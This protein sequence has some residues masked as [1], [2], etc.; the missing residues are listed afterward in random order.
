MENKILAHNLDDRSVWR[1]NDVN[2]HN[3]LE[4]KDNRDEILIKQSFKASETSKSFRDLIPVEKSISSIKSTTFSMMKIN[5]TIVNDLKRCGFL[6]PSPIQ[7]SCIPLA[8]LG[9]DLIAQSKSGT[10]KTLVFVICSLEMI[11]EEIYDRGNFDLPKSVRALILIPTHEIANQIAEIIES[12]TSNWKNFVCYRAIG[13]T[14]VSDDLDRLNQAQIVVGT[15]GRV[16]SLLEW[17]HLKTHSI[18]LFVLDECDK[19]MDENFKRQ[20][21]RIFHYLPANKQMI[22]TSATMTEEMCEYLERYMQNPS[23][24]RLDADQP[25]LLGVRQYILEVEG[26]VLEYLNF[27]SKLNTLLYL[28]RNIHYNQCFIFSNYQTRVQYL[29]DRIRT[30]NFK[31]AMMSGNMT[32]KD[33]HESIEM[34]RQQKFRIIISTDLT[35]RG[36]D[37]DS[38]NLVI[39]IDV[40][41]DCETYLH[42][43]GRSGRF[44]SSGTAI[45]IVG[46]E[47]FE[48]KKF[49]DILQKYNLKPNNL[50]LSSVHKL[51][52]LQFRNEND[53]FD[54]DIETKL[55]YLLKINPIYE[56][57]EKMM[58][59]IDS[60][61]WNKLENFDHSAT[62]STDK[63]FPDRN[64]SKPTEELATESNTFDDLKHSNKVVN[65]SINDDDIESD[66]KKNPMNSNETSESFKYFNRN[67]QNKK[68]EMRIFSKN[69]R[70]DLSKLS[71]QG[72]GCNIDDQDHHNHQ[73]SDHI[74]SLCRKPSNSESISHLSSLFRKNFLDSHRI[75]AA[76]I[77]NQHCSVLQSSRTKRS[78][79][80]KSN[81][82]FQKDSNEIFK[83]LLNG[84]NLL[85]Q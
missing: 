30:E 5:Q 57:I 21:D 33:R 41:I 23:W 43:I 48:K 62:Q 76:D 52:D 42:R 7:T 79:P 40:P 14:K 59:E 16:L 51:W 37:I 71:H 74:P 36:I 18:R 60:D 17:C 85:E 68:I 9:I 4:H 58:T 20:I 39:N 83:F 54:N 84:N 66:Y 27:E 44:G 63:I 64:T 61:Q 47:S 77:I 26:H 34:F 12:L 78:T 65:N 38:V 19:L 73:P 22:A 15:P 28:L 13:G 69:F 46:R 25:S 55:D 3:Y 70:N 6:Y 67:Y 1:S 35:S 2:L 82:S 72:D 32:Q 31:V 24:I 8:R 75:I 11:V 81:D 53:S 29:Y 10:G 49:F 45:T 50:E 80:M 56:R